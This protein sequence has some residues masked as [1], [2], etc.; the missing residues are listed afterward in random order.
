MRKEL[1]REKEER[2]AKLS[3]TLK[4]IKG[5]IAQ[6][7]EQLSTL[8]KALATSEKS[9]EEARKAHATAAAG[10]EKAKAAHEAVLAEQAAGSSGQSHQQLLDET[11]RRLAAEAEV[12]VA[13][14]L[15][16][17]ES[18]LVEAQ[19]HATNL[20]NKLARGRAVVRDAVLNAH[21]MAENVPAVTSQELELLVEKARQHTEDVTAEDL[22]RLVTAPFRTWLEQS[23]TECDEVRARCAPV[24][25]GASLILI[26]SSCEH[27]VSSCLFVRCE[28]LLAPFLAGV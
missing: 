26:L 28:V 23:Y 24:A 12:R 7:D 20:G 10:W 22:H 8:R 25:K 5:E 21:E 19:S 13:E 1:A 14:R 2:V 27:L 9:A 17:L 15:S 4:D 18:Q 3:A 6:R 16:A 11:V